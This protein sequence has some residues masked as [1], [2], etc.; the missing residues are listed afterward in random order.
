MFYHKFL[1]SKFDCYPMILNKSNNAGLLSH[2][3]DV[4][5]PDNDFLLD[6]SSLTCYCVCVSSHV[7][8]WFGVR[9]GA[10]WSQATRP[11]RTPVPPPEWTRGPTD[12]LT[13]SGKKWGQ[14]RQERFKTQEIRTN[15]WHLWHDISFLSLSLDSSAHYFNF[16]AH[17]FASFFQNSHLF[18]LKLSN[19]IS[20][21]RLWYLR[22]LAFELIIL[23]FS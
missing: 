3:F 9:G 13:D 11:S 10:S 22:W 5:S 15:Y 8:V 16:L 6:W 4:I 17:N 21:L 14:S 12:S 20:E 7:R 2:N 23:I 19:F 18:H 1:T